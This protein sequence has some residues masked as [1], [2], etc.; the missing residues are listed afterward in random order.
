[1]TDKS[2]LLISLNFPPSQM[3]GVHRTRHLA[4]HL[5]SLGWRPIVLAVDERFHKEPIDSVL[6]RLVP[7]N[8]EVH[9][10]KAVP[11]WATRPIGLGDLAIRSLYQTSRKID[12]LMTESRPR[13]V[14]VTGPPFYHMLLASRI[15][16]KFGV[17]VILDFQD[18]WVSA[19]GARRP[20]WSKEGMT[21]RLA[22]ALEPHALR[23][24]DYIT[25]VSDRQNLEMAAR[26]EWLDRSRMAAIPIGGDPDDFDA[27]R[28]Q[29]LENPQVRLDRAK[30]NLSYVGTFL[31]RAEPLVRHLFR[32]LSRLREMEPELAARVHL[33]FIGT[34]NQ[35]N[36]QNSF[37]VIPIAA[38]EGVADLVSETPQRV[39]FLESL[40][41]L[42]NSN[43]LL[44]IGSDEPHYTASKIYPALM[45]GR[46]YLS[47]FHKASSSHTI[48][49]A[50]GGGLTFAFSTPDE[51]AAL[52]M[53]L[54]TG[55]RT[56]AA[57]PTRLGQANPAVY[58]AYQANAIARQYTE[59]F[60]MLG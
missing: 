36:N 32:A 49:S 22:V 24:A 7:S 27:L 16:R 14:F 8:V 58:G 38:E 17:P 55:L 15:K 2:A 31:P 28:A 1:M 26:Y 20:K 6:G 57:A 19:Y 21:H 46:P 12:R 34:S 35:P 52:T 39:A 41:V 3:A 51:L 23:S 50:A 54:V 10:I 37:R 47:L 60:D 30:I 5:P 9:R 11:L 44:L 4:K 33:N 43:G 56:L 18:P 53:A 29:P 45:S 59:I 48:L 13:V 40:S 42:A 25:S